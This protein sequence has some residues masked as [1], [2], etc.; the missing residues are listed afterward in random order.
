MI[1]SSLA[2]ATSEACACEL[3]VGTAA[4]SIAAELEAAVTFVEPTEKFEEPAPSCSGEEL[5]LIPH[6]L[7]EDRHRFLHW[8]HGFAA[9]LASIE[10][11]NRN[12]AHVNQT[13]VHTSECRQKPVLDRL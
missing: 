4:S 8:L 12:D 6:L 5:Q 2:A 10:S 9:E 1:Q 3:E 11:K 7:L 13:N